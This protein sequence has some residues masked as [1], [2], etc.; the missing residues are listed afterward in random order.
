MEEKVFDGDFFKV[1]ENLN[2][3]IKKSASYGASGAR[4]SRIKGTSVE[5]SD[6]REYIHGDDFRRIDWNA[7]GRFDKFFVK[8]FMEEREALINVFVDCSS[9]MDF[10]EPKKS[11]LAL[12]LAAAFS[13]LTLS[14]LDRVCINTL[15]GKELRSQEALSGKL[16]LQRALS[17]L[18]GIE[19]D[20]TT[21][22]NAAIAKKDFK[23]KGVSIIISDFFTTNG[24][25]EAVKY[26]T[27]R[28]QEVILLHLLSPEE[29]KPEYYGQVKLIDSETKEERSIILNTAIIK[30]YKKQLEAFKSGLKDSASKYGAKYVE[31]SSDENIEEVI[32]GKLSK[33]GILEK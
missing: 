16:M 20:G 17:L 19:F 30:A 11:M 29:L 22:I 7:Y 27:Y 9:S 26:L 10:G 1:L 3:S 8:L 15:R 23:S 5:F 18:K 6:Y 2:I 32:L 12:K 13:Y 28:K 4:K 33:G 24:I 14:S 25:T 21:D 31:V